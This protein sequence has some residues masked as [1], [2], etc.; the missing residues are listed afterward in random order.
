[1]TSKVDTGA[2]EKNKVDTGYGKKSGYGGERKKWILEERK[3]WI[4]EEREKSRH[5]RE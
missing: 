5:R 1:M 4:L 3:K 2:G